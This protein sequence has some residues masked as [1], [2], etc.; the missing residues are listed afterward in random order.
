LCA[1]G[2]VLAFVLSDWVIAVV[3]AGAAAFWIG[4]FWIGRNR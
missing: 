2:V 1:L 3:T 4:L